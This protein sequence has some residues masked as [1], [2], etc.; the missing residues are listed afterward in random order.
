MHEFL[1]KSLSR[2]QKLSPSSPGFSVRGDAMNLPS[3]R[4]M[5]ILC[6]RSAVVFRIIGATNPT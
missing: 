3:I 2:W 4:G 5:I 1:Q 6:C